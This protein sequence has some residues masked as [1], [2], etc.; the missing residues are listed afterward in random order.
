MRSQLMKLI[1]LLAV[2]LTALPSYAEDTSRAY[3]T[4]GADGT[5]IAILNH[6]NSTCNL[7]SSDLKHGFLDRTLPPD[8]IPSGVGGVFYIYDSA[9]GPEITL[10]YNC[11]GKKITL[12]NQQNMAWLW[13]GRVTATVLSADEGI[14]ASAYTERGSQIVL[15]TGKI[16][17]TIENQ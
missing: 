13:A 3:L 17:W 2:A 9:F 7:E 11:G 15:K 12:Y 14:T 8:H 5:S 6:T 16:L 10:S 4:N 1:L